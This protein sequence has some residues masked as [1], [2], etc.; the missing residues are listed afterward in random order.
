M[1]GLLRAS[2]NELHSQLLIQLLITAMKLGTGKPYVAVLPH[3]G[4]AHTHSILLEWGGSSSPLQPPKFSLT[5]VKAAAGFAA[6]CAGY[7]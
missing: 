6:L 1:G 4:G 7:L 5:S 3:F 2:N